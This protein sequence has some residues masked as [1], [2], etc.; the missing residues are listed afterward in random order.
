MQSGTAPGMWPRFKAKFIGDRAFYKMALILVIPV[1]VQNTVTNFVNL[2]DNVMVGSL[3]TAHMSGVSIANHLMF[4]FNLSIFGAL[5][6]A[7]IYGAQLA[8]AKDWSG[9]RETLRFRLYV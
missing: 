9:F 3:G 6:G 2:L 4:V 8:G 7:G 1:I 5:S